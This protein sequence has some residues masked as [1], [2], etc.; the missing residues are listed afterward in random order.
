MFGDY[1]FIL[2]N[3]DHNIENHN[4]FWFKRIYFTNDFKISGDF[5]TR[6]RFE[7]YSPGDF[8]LKDKLILYLK[9]VDFSNS[10]SSRDFGISFHGYLDEKE[11]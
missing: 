5:S 9:P 3:H 10:G 4:G 2:S 1:Y 7:M 8:L 6:L 11:K